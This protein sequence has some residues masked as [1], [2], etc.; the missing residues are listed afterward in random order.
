M[1]ERRHL[2]L[3]SLSTLRLSIW[4]DAYGDRPEEKIAKTSTVPN[5]APC[6]LRG[7]FLSVGTSSPAPGRSVFFP[8][9]RFGHR[10][11]TPSGIHTC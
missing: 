4:S 6:P 3:G 8:G 9:S 1:K 5:A 2:D 11:K 10:H 7:N